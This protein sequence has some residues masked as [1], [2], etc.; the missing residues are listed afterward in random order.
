MVRLSLSPFYIRVELGIST[1]RSYSQIHDYSQQSLCDYTHQSL[2][3]YTRQSHYHN[4]YPYKPI[5]TQL[6]Y[7]SPFMQFGHSRRWNDSSW[8]H[9]EVPFTIKY[10]NLSYSS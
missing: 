1:K 2:R 9:T 4:M 3:D 7:R 5:N 6:D 8:V 10:H